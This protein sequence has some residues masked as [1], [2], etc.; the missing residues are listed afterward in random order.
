MTLKFVSPPD[1]ERPSD[2]DA[3][4]LYDVTIEAFDPMS[5]ASDTAATTI[6]VTDVDEAVQ[7][8]E[9]PV[10]LS[11]N[12][13]EVLAG[14]TFVTVVV[15]RDNGAVTLELSGTDQSAFELTASGELRFLTPASF[16]SPLDQDQDNIYSIEIIATDSSGNTAT[17]SVTIA[18][19]RN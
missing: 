2:V 12:E 1:F 8:T 16:E 15:T 14:G 6:S 11:P 5:N 10:F 9:A 19:L 3:N 18:V 17:Q 13:F 7:D 4:N